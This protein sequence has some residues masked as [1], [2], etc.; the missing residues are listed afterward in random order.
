MLVSSSMEHYLRTPFPE[1]IIKS[2]PQADITNYRHK[3]QFWEALFKFKT[4][5]VH[6]CLCIIEKYQLLY[7]KTCQ[8]T[9]KFR[10]N[11]TGSTGNHYLLACKVL[12]NLLDVDFYFITTKQV[13]NL[14]FTNVLFHYLSVNYLVD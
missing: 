3:I 12:L 1:C 11:G 9:A 10:A 13:F 5:I 2:R 6:R 14:D 8:L 4:E 7:A